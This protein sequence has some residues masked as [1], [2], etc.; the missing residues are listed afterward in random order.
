MSVE[1][2]LREELHAQASVRRELPAVGHIHARAARRRRRRTTAVGAA[3]VV[4]AILVVTA[5]AVL[6][7]QQ[8]P[9]RIAVLAAAPDATRSAGTARVEVRIGVRETMPLALAARGQIDFGSQRAVLDTWAVVA[10]TG[11]PFHDCTHRRWFFDGPRVYVPLSYLDQDTIPPD[12]PDPASGP[13]VMDRDGTRLADVLTFGLGNPA[14]A[15]NLVDAV[16]DRGALTNRVATTMRH[17]TTTRFD[18]VIPTLAL[19]EY[20]GSYAVQQVDHVGLE[21]YVDSEG[22]LARIVAE[23]MYPPAVPGGP[24]FTQVRQVD[25]LDFGEPVTITL[26]RPD[27]LAVEE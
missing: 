19:R 17:T 22:R 7:Q 13:W 25:F 20:L 23:W 12:C 3:A 24:Q 8:T 18:A 10:D 4:A 15:T 6:P 1:S 9:A 27:Q 26:P 21:L 5:A 16:I 2:R 11:K 14:Q